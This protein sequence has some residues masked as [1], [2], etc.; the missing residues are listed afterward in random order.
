MRKFL[1]ENLQDYRDAEMECKLLRQ[2]ILP[3]GDELYLVE[4]L[5]FQEI[6]DKATVYEIWI[7][8][9]CVNTFFNLSD[10]KWYMH[11]LFVR[12]SEKRHRYS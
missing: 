2:S 7:N 3:S 12:A 9:L 11:L 1:D 10:A 6:S 4:V 8:G 5:N